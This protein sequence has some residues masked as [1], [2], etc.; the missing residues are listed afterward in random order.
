M[1]QTY[2]EDSTNLLATSSGGLLLRSSIT[3]LDQR[4]LAEE[5]E[6]DEPTLAVFQGTAY[7]YGREISFLFKGAGET[8]LRR[9]IGCALIGI[10]PEEGIEEALWSLKDIFEFRAQPPLL[11]L[12][13]PM[14]A[15]QNTGQIVTTAE[16]P[17][18]II[19]E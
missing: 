13:Q 18:L 3:P 15:I 17:D 5:E 6:Q 19:S 9:L 16:R 10:M 7:S 2:F 11:M 4:K 8:A 12:T 1:F 14:R